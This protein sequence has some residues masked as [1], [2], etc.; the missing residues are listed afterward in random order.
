M[1]LF[2][3]CVAKNSKHPSSELEDLDNLQI[4]GDGCSVNSIV[5]TTA[6]I[7]FRCVLNEGNWVYQNTKTL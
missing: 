5:L 2:I 1:Q 6:S 3:G 7:R 4:N